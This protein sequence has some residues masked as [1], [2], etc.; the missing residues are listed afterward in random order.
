MARDGVSSEGSTRG[1][2]AS[3]LTQWLLAGF[4][5]SQAVGLR[6][7]APH[8]LLACG[9][10]Q[11]LANEGFSTD[12]LPAWQLAFLRA[13]ERERGC[14]RRKPQSFC[15]LTSHC[16]RLTHRVEANHQA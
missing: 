5:C 7:S 6:P 15:E 13:S 11:F 16:F 12:Q 1:R 14:A 3:K 4:G 8:W 10:L 9:L 2:F